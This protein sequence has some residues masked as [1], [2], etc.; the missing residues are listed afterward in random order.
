MQNITQ[1]DRNRPAQWL[2][3]NGVQARTKLK[4]STIYLYIR[5][6]GFPKPVKVG[7]R[8]YWIESEVEAWMQ[9]QMHNR[10]GG[11]WQLVS[12]PSAATDILLD[13]QVPQEEKRLPSKGKGRGGSQTQPMEPFADKQTLHIPLDNAR[14]YLDAATNTIRVEFQNAEL[15][16]NVGSE[17]RRDIG[18]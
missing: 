9:A 4:K 13:V 16:L 1:F 17:D 12:K 6:H 14:F 11:P 10:L 2:D 5:T 8:S 18:M 15:S 3:R 7:S